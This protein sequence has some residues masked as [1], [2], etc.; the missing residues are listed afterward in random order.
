MTQ[1]GKFQQSPSVTCSDT[2]PQSSSP[3]QDEPGDNKRLATHTLMHI[4]E[5]RSTH[6]GSI[7]NAETG[8]KDDSNRRQTC[9]N[10][11]IL[12]TKKT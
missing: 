11:R 8:I 3:T 12:P 6:I 9:T 7:E 10:S 1:N 5:N 2:L 4:N